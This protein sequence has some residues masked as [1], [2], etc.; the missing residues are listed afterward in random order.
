MEIRS[1]LPNGI[2]SA[3]KRVP[4]Y[5]NRFFTFELTHWPPRRYG[6]NYK[7]LFF[8]PIIPNNSLGTLSEIALSWMPEDLPNKKST[9]VHVMVWCHQAT[10]HN[11]SQCRPRFM[12][13]YSITKPQW[14]NKS[15][16]NWPTGNNFQFSRNVSAIW[17]KS[18][19]WDGNFLILHRKL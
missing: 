4:L 3:D 6:S 19:L 7:S 17:Q 13:S 9:L 8:K 15:Q 1:Y 12:S 14:V 5:W 18:K 11:L 2:A 10:S 16:Y